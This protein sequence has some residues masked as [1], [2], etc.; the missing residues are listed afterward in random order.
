V[1]GRGV[2]GKPGGVTAFGDRSPLGGAGLAGDF[3]PLD[4]GG[5]AAGSGAVTGDHNEAFVEVF[6]VFFRDIQFGPDAVRVGRDDPIIE[7]LHLLDQAR[8]VEIASGG[9]HAHGLGHLQRGDQDVAL[10]DA[11]VGDVA[12]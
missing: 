1:V 2:A 11:Y 8:L 5:P 9:E 4:C 7:A 10:S 12:L 6:K 3:D